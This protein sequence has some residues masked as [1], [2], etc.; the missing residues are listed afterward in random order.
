[1]LFDFRKLFRQMTIAAVG[2]DWA[3]QIFVRKL[4]SAKRLL[5]DLKAILGP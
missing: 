4:E 3:P 5:G 2:D 1:M